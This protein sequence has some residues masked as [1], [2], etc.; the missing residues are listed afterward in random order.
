[1]D[2]FW[3]SVSIV[4]GALL[5]AGC[6]VRT[7]Y[8]VDSGGDTGEVELAEVQTTAAPAVDEAAPLPSADVALPITELVPE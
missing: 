8:G 5:A 4:M 7:K 3:R 1:M 2:R 6:P